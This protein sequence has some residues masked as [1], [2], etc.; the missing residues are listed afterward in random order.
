VSKVN[1]AAVNTAGIMRGG[2][3]VVSVLG[4][5]APAAGLPQGTLLNP[6][7]RCVL[8]ASEAIWEDNTV[9]STP[10]AEYTAILQTVFSFFDVRWTLG[11]ENVWDPII[12]GWKK[13]SG[14]GRGTCGKKVLLEAGANR[15]RGKAS[16]Y[17]K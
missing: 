7:T 13:E 10:L 5:E 15:A 6:M 17:Y 8:I 3:L 16:L 4:A 9:P 2:A 1:K 11:G 12:T 14:G